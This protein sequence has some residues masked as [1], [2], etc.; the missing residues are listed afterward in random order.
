MMF[1]LYN[2]IRNCTISILTQELPFDKLIIFNNNINL[3]LRIDLNLLLPQACDL[4]RLICNKSNCFSGITVLHKEPKP[5]LI[6]YI[7]CSFLAN[8]CSKC[9]RPKITFSFNLF[10]NVVFG[11]FYH[12]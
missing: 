11:L 12:M 7:A 8:I 3:E 2:Q 5:V 1:S 6:P 10:N 9:L 4:I